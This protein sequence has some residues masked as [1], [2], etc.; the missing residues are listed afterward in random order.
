MA[1][2]CKR[3]EKEF[4]PEERSQYLGHNMRCAKQ[5]QDALLAQRK[6][7]LEAAREEEV[8]QNVGTTDNPDVVKSDSFIY[9]TKAYKKLPSPIVRHLELTFGN[10]LNYFEI[11]QEWR[12]DYG[13]YGIYIKIPRKYSTEWRD[14]TSPAYDNATRK[15]TG[16]QK[17]AIQDIRSMPMK[18]LPNVMKWLGIVRTNIIQNAINKG[19]RLPS[20]DIGTDVNP[21]SIQEKQE[22]TIA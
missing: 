6:E 15:I 21:L 16:Y 5:H 10:W 8:V 14:D 4:T 13:G 17:T 12:E 11:G 7:R 1:F 18:D 2:K 9:D 19:L 20:T 3:C 22:K